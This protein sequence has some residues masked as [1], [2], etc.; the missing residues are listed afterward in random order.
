MEFF[1]LKSHKVACDWKIASFK[2]LVNKKLLTLW[3]SVRDNA[4]KVI[5]GFARIN[6]RVIKHPGVHF[7]ATDL[8]ISWNEGVKMKDFSG[9]KYLTWLVQ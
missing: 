4:I 3:F 1:S 6:S 5:F 9:T 7:Y 2:K 8:Y